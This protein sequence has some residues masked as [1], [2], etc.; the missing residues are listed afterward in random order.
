[1]PAAECPLDLA[2][3]GVTGLAADS[4][5]VRPG[6]LFLAV[7]GAR[8]DG[9]A[10]IAEA[11]ARGARAVLAPEDTPAMALPEGVALL[12][13]ETPRRLFARLAARLSGAQPAVI[14]AVTGTSGK[15][16]V[17]EFIRQLWGLLG[18]PAASLGTLGLRAPGACRAGSLTTPDPVRLHRELARLAGEGIDRLALEASSHGL[19][20]YRLD[21]V[22]V[23]TGVFTNLSRDHLDYHPDLESYLEAKLGLFRR[24]MTP[25]GLAVA[26]GDDPAG[27]AAADAARA[28]GH[29]V[30]RFGRPGA[31]N[32]IEIEE[33]APGEGGQLLRFRFRGARRRVRLA[34]IGAFQARNAL[35][36]LGAV[37]GRCAD[38][39]PAMDRLEALKGVRGR[40]EFAAR[41]PSGAPVYVDYAHKPGAL[42]AALEALR[43]ALRGRLA[44]VFGAGGD[45]DPGKR[46]E[47]GR[48][49]ARLA[50]RVIVTDDNPRSEDPARIR[51]AILAGCPGAVEIADRADAIAAG[52]EG[53]GA[54]D[55]L[56]IAGKGHET[57]QIVGER[58]QPFD[59]RAV[60]REAAG[61]RA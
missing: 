54:G 14:A 43:P 17:V 25:G 32:A 36:A 19:D 30:L 24:V 16:S 57:G 55:A 1:M 42:A 60:A 31:G 21:G 10:F 61:W 41:A 29:D 46:A 2:A 34:L 51:A 37:A 20:Q 39:G 53:L 9:R 4:R 26:N 15:T 6:D 7:P 38:A 44:V 50:D 40:L 12:R 18:A 58:V 22:R 28:A 47:M 45:R 5:E 48:V 35:A 11:L 8:A 13:H 49:A 33:A 56:L 27:E 52:V 59:D 23:S 3:L